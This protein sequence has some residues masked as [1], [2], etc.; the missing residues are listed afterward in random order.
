MMF[1]AAWQKCSRPIGFHRVIYV[2]YFRRTYR[3]QSGILYVW[4]YSENR[5]YS[6]ISRQTFLSAHARAG[7]RTTDNPVA[8]WGPLGAGGA[9]AGACVGCGVI[10]CILDSGFCQLDIRISDSNF[11]NK[12]DLSDV[13]SRTV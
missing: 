7:R 10:F 1:N 5:K 12:P 13:Y 4:K 9:S 11:E 6:R 2:Q 8:C 3:L